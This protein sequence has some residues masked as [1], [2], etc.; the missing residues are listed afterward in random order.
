MKRSKLFLGATTAL[1]AIVGIMSAKAHKTFI[2]LRYYSLAHN[3]TRAIHNELA[4]TA[5]P[6]LVIGFTKYGISCDG[7]PVY[8][9][10][11]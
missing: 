5:G 9:G 10:E 11:Q 6:G 8:H 1:L 4:K 2:G 7:Q 3:C